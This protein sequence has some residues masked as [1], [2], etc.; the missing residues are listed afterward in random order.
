MNRPFTIEQ[1]AAIT[2]VH[3]MRLDYDLHH[4]SAQVITRADCRR[5]VDEWR[6]SPRHAAV[7]RAAATP[8]RIERFNHRLWH[9]HDHSTALWTVL[10]LAFIAGSIAI[11][12]GIWKP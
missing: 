8:T 5:A 10:G 2:K 6:Q 4:R 9:K 11:T 3:V 12:T 7:V 1:N